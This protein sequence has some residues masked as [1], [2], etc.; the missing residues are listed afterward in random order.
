MRPL[1]SRISVRASVIS[2]SAINLAL[3]VLI[4]K[5]AESIFS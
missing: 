5:I 3:W 2:V 1:D 4:V